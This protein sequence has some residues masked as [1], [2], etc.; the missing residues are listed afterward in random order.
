MVTG[1]PTLQSMI[2]QEVPG[3]SLPLQ[4]LLPMA[5]AGADLGTNLSQEIMMEMEK[6]TLPSTIPPQVPGGSFLLLVLDH[7]GK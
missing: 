3:G 5:M 1:K 2:P 7:K 4:V 6:Q